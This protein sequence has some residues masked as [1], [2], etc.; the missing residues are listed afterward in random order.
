[1]TPYQEPQQTEQFEAILGAVIMAAVI[2]AGLGLLTYLIK[3]K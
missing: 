2:G 3:R 1:M